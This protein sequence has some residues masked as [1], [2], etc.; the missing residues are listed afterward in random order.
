MGPH[1]G[2]GAGLPGRGRARILLAGRRPGV[3]RRPGGRLGQ[4]V[5]AD[6]VKRLAGAPGHVCGTSPW[7]WAD[8]RGLLVPAMGGGWLSLC[9]RAGAE[10]SHPLVSLNSRSS[11]LLLPGTDAPGGSGETPSPPA[12]L[13]LGGGG[14]RAQGPPTLTPRPTAPPEEGTGSAQAGPVSI[15]GAGA[16][17]SSPVV[18]DGAGTL[19]AH[20]ACPSRPTEPWLRVSRPKKWLLHAVVGPGL[21]RTAP[22]WVRG[23]PR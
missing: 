3:S 15:S 12:S 13:P 7:F 10:P 5:P 1:A 19:G 23:A 20:P 6:G 22:E 2:L 14:S 11:F 9:I 4:P 17:P 16:S 18:G 8:S 21:A